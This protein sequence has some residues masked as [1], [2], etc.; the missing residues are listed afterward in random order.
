MTYNSWR[1]AAPH[2]DSLN[3]E[4]EHY[5]TLTPCSLF[6]VQ[7]RLSQVVKSF[8]YLTNFTSVLL[9]NAPDNALYRQLFAEYLATLDKAPI[10]HTETLDMVDLFG[11]VEV[12]QGAIV[13]E[14]QGLLD[15]ANQGYLV[16]SANL[17][18]ANL[19]HWPKL[20]AALLG[21][22]VTRFQTNTKTIK[23][24]SWHQYQVKLVIL[25]EREQLA[26]LYDLDDDFTTGFSLFGEL[27]LDFKITQTSLTHY[28]SYLRWFTQRYQLPEL[29]QDGVLALLK[30]GARRNEDQH[31]ASLCVLW[32]GALLTQAST[33]ASVL[34]ANAIE[35]ALAQRE[36]GA[37][38]LIEQ[39]L[40]DLF[41]GQVI[42]ET[43]GKQIGQ[44]NGLTVVDL[45]GHPISYGEP[46]RISCVVYFGDGDIA[47]VE[48]KVELGGNV[49]AKGMM[50]MQAFLCHTLA[51][52]GPL[53]FTASIVFEQSYSEIDGDSAS[54]AELCALMSALANE[55]I[56]Q[57]KAITGAVDQFGNALSIGGI[58]EKIE[59]FYRI[60]RHQGF[61]GQQGV[62][63]P[64][65]NIRHLVLANEVLESLKTGEFH[66]WPIEHIDEAIP[67][68][69]N[70]AFNDE[71]DNSLI[72]LIQ[73]RIEHQEHQHAAH[74][75][76][77]QRIKNAFIKTDR[78]C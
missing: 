77:L 56:D 46:A 74:F 40:N 1:F 51:L 22:A 26:Q 24:N 18:L 3:A 32:L 38:Y 23:V 60:C 64:K 9:I 34:D 19:R 41:T 13:Q 45:T 5:S 4:F 28:L 53:P 66:L 2:Y 58:N 65:A 30:A 21:D 55:P 20:K 42:I 48:R 67:L 7:P 59:G 25:A 49:H 44:I 36:F 69:F 47:D 12:K 71:S 75:S 68:L 62:I 8:T 31:Y 37:S 73:T 16:V 39:A 50:V 76:L 70:K 72:S 54:L 17:L 10:L 11:Q 6:D 27:E 63:F 57:Q 43:Q 14:T 61:T 33:Q 15:Q 29:T 78:T 52:E 35:Q